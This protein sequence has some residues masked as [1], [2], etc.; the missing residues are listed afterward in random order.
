MVKKKPKKTAKKT[1]EKRPEKK[2]GKLAKNPA[3]KPAKK[4]AGKLAAKTP[5]KAPEKAPEKKSKPLVRKEISLPMDLNSQAAK[6]RREDESF[7]DQVADG[8]RRH[9]EARE[10]DAK[11]DGEYIG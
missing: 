11:K 5:E 2:P 6:V 8:L 1:S 7:S 9:V 4:Q 10:R 3:A